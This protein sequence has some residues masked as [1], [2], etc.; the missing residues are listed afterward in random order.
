MAIARSAGNLHFWVLLLAA[1]I[2]AL[3]WGMAHG[4]TDIDRPFDLP[5]ELT[6]LGDG[7]VVTELSAPEVN[8]RVLG[9][10]AALR[11]VKAASLYYQ[12]DVAGAKSGTAEYEVD[13]SQ[14][15]SALPRN[16]RIVSRSPAHIQVRFEGKTRKAVRVRAD[17]E[18]EPSPGFRVASVTVEPARVWL[19]GARSQVLRL[20]EVATDPVDV[21]GLAE[22]VEREARISLATPTVWLEDKQPVRVKI[23]IE[24]EDSA[25][26]QASPSAPSRSGSGVARTTRGGKG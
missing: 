23:E 8:I 18:G 7:L 1:G 4:Q 16:V 11:N 12:L 15:E 6:G 2:A 10:R 26:K 21:A 3:L 24:P 9:S 14:V 5:V 17:M 19:A 20:S 22:S 13:L 25:A